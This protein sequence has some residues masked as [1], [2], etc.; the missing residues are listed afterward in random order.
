MNIEKKKHIL[1]IFNNY[2]RK[3]KEFIQKK[4]NKSKEQIEREIEGEK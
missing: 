3:E 4:K 1:K 2:L